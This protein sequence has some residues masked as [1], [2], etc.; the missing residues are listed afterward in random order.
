MGIRRLFQETFRRKSARAP[1][2]GNLSVFRIPS[3]VGRGSRVREYNMCSDTDKFLAMSVCTPLS[4]VIGKMGDMLSG[5]SVYVTDHNGDEKRKYAPIRDLLNSPNPMQ[6]GPSFLRS[7]E[8]SLKLYGYCPVY[9]LRGGVFS[10]SPPTAMYVIPPHLFHMTATG[11]LFSQ[12]EIGGIVEEAYIDWGG[13]QKTLEDG[14]F[15]VIYDSAFRIEG[16]Y[17]DIRFDSRTDGLSAPVNGWIASMRTSCRMVTDGGPKGIVYYDGGTEMGN[18]MDPSDKEELERKL[19]ERYGL[20]N[21]FPVAAS[22]VKVGWVPLDFNADQ[23]KIAELDERCERKIC[24]AFG[25]N[26]SLFNDA[27][28]DNQESAKKSAYQDV[29]IPD[30]NNIARA[31]TRALC[32]ADAEIRFDFSHVE[33]LQADRNRTAQALGQTADALGSLTENGLI[34]VSEARVYLASLMDIDPGKIPERRTRAD[35]YG[36]DENQ[37]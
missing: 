28:Y 31:L 2:S 11:K 19:M 21:G 37:E 20:F 7:V 1:Y 6:T 33:C 27:K 29:I 13:M 26:Y 35:G 34:D 32:P 4:A 15:F 3:I 17:S 8:M 9:T 16:Q 14:E 30:A 22:P 10:D 5:A 18:T 24:G 25:I 12:S 36:T 23:L